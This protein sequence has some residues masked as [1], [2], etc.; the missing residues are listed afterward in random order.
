M[1]ISGFA[2]RVVAPRGQSLV[3]GLDLVGHLGPGPRLA[4]VPGR[5]AKPLAQSR[6]AAE[7]LDLRRQREPVPEREQQPALALADQL[8]VE[9]EVGDD[10]HGAGRERLPDEAGGCAHAAGGE[11]SDVRAGQELGRFAVPRAHNPETLP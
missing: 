11:H 4:G 2:F 8:A 7:P 10:R 5:D 3:D 1:R 9:L 6:V